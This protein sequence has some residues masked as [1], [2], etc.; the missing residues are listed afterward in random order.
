GWR[1]HHSFA[2]LGILLAR[3]T[4]RPLG[5]HLAEDLLAPLGRRPAPGAPGRGSDARQRNAGGAS[6]GHQHSPDRDVPGSDP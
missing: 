3:L 2:V 1:Y 6:P 5:E 4:G